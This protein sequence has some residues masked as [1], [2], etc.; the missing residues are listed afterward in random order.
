MT[1]LL[2]ACPVLRMEALAKN[3]YDLLVKSESIAAVA[4]PGQFVH[5]RVPG[6]TLRRPISLCETDVERGTLRLVFEVRGE[7]TRGL[8]QA[9]VGDTL[10]V[11]GPLGHGFTVEDLSQP[12]LFVGGG[13]G[14]PP[15]LEAAKRFGEYATV[16]LGFRNA[17]AQILTGDFAGYGCQVMVATDDGSA[18]HHGLVTDLVIQRL[19]EGPVS[20]IYA[21]GPKP[22][23]KALV[24]LVA[25]HGIP[26]EVS[27]EER[28]GCGVGACLV[29]ACK[30]RRE[31]GGETYRHVC[32]DGPVFPAEEVVFE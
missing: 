6:F 13:I 3:T 7:G 22:M 18:G 27:L 9:R 16:V 32:K 14:T 17:A 15:L 26:C 24:A 8:A 30:A 20:R 29:C 21:C 1:Y 28:M 10:D 5:V 19:K 31:D 25:E 23:L 11:M 4:S 2:D 12:V